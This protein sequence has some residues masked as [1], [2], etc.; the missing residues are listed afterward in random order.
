VTIGQALTHQNAQ[1]R[2][3]EITLTT[4]TEI[5]QMPFGL[6]PS[7]HKV[8]PRILIVSFVEPA[9]G[10]LIS[11]GRAPSKGWDLNTSLAFGI[12]TSG[13][14]LSSLFKSVC[15]KRKKLFLSVKDNE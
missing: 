3:Y 9:I 2:E 12:L 10:S 11:H 1:N 15:H 4:P 14:F 6:D 8:T 5:S 13:G 7:L